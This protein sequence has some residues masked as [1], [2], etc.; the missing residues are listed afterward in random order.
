[1]KSF[2]FGSFPG[3]LWSWWVNGQYGFRNWY[4]KC[5]SAHSGNSGFLSCPCFCWEQAGMQILYFGQAV[6]NTFIW[7]LFITIFIV[8]GRHMRFSCWSY[9]LSICQF[10]LLI[11]CFLMYTS[12]V[13]RDISRLL[14]KKKWYMSSLYGEELYFSWYE[15]LHECMLE[16]LYYQ[17]KPWNS[18]G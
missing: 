12:Y 5:A 8:L 3:V 11:R 6:L 1:M 15:I 14:V 4:V 13:L 17:V 7:S 2:I 16:G 18:K 9:S 10:L